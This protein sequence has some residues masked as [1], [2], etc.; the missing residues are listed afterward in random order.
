MDYWHASEHIHALARAAYGEGSARA[1]RWARDHCRRLK[2]HGP[3]P[4]L[5]ALRRLRP[6]NAQQAEA[7]R[8]ELRY[9]G[10]NRARMQY[11][12][13]RARG[14]MIGSGP[15]EAACKVVVGARLKQ[16]GMRWAAAGADALLA[17]RT[18]ILS[19]Q[20]ERIRQAARAA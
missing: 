12:Q 17:V 19:G 3:R 8:L 13:F 10:N 7:I 20:H 18:T 9:F 16:S 11:A 4:L 14:L 5:R 6:D 2:E 15:V 1:E